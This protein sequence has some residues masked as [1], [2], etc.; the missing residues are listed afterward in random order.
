MF[1]IFWTPYG[2]LALLHIC[3]HVMHIVSASVLASTAQ[4]IQS[5]QTPR[6]ATVAG[7]NA[8]ACCLT[9][10][11]SPPSGRSCACS[12]SCA[13]RCRRR[14][15]PLSWSGCGCQ[16]SGLLWRSCSAPA[17]ARC[18]G[19]LRNLPQTGVMTAGCML[20]LAPLCITPMQLPAPPEP[21]ENKKLACYK[22][23]EAAQ[24]R[25]P[26]VLWSRLLR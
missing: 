5:K 13:S 11:M 9:G 10:R 4:P 17:V 23:P 12:G 18:C 6:F 7:A 15:C 25:L 19:G 2:P 16:R 26:R 21:T 3:H 22:H 20:Q 1:A 14:R 8:R 24:E